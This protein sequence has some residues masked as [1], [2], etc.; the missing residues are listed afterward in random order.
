MQR[1]F[2]SKL[3]SSPV[4]KVHSLAAS[5]CDIRVDLCMTHYIPII[6][7]LQALIVVDLKMYNNLFEWS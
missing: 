6:G 2:G 7:A 1:F 3:I 4:P 5:S